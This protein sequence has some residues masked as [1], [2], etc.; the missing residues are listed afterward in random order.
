M[1]TI[2]FTISFLVLSSYAYSYNF[3]IVNSSFN[4]VDSIDLGTQQYVDATMTGSYTSSDKLQIYIQH[5]NPNGSEVNLLKLLDEVLWTYYLSLPL[6]TDGVSRRI[7]FNM[8]SS[9]L[10]G[11]FSINISLT[12]SRA[13][14]LIK[15]PSVV[16]GIFDHFKFNQKVEI[17]YYCE[18]GIEIEKPTEGFYIWRSSNG[19]SGKSFLID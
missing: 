9:Y 3:T 18:Q 10:S 14:G 7:Y 2:I 5:V 16:S 11:K 19:L 12:P 15:N 8:P 17:K 1:K 13:I 6:N 4:Q